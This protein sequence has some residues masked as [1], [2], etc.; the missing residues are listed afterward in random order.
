VGAAGAVHEEA[1]EESFRSEWMPALAATPDARLLYF[2][3]LAHGTGRAYNFV[4]VTGVT[5]GA[6]WDRL[7]ERLQLG[8]LRAWAARVDGMR[9]DV[10]A[11]ILRPAD[12]SPLQAVAFDHVP[13]DG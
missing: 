4:T 1:F 5:D 2:M 12:W 11:K 9:W 13:T 3:R 10:T 6:A 7:A 8:D